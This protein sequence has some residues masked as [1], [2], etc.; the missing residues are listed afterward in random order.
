M[1]RIVAICF[2]SCVV[3]GYAQANEQTGIEQNP[4][5]QNAVIGIN[6]FDECAALTMWL[7]AGGRVNDMVDSAKNNSN[8]DQQPTTNKKKWLPFGI[9]DSAIDKIPTIKI[10]KGWSVV[11]T[12]WSHNNEPLL[13]ICH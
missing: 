4:I 9:G 13:F 5:K 12:G 7:Y 1:K 8:S 10:P 2:F 6:S 11:G 3:A